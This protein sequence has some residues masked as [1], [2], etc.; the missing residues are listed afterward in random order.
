LGWALFALMT[1]GIVI[2]GLPA[3]SASAAA[4]GQITGT[5][6]Y[7][8]SHPDRT[9]EVYRYTSGTWTEDPSLRTTVASDGS[10]TVQAPAGEPVELR[11]SY[12]Q[13]IYGYFYGDGFDADTATPV[14]AAAGATTTGIDLDVPAPSYLSGRLV[15]RAGQPV[16]GTV[17]PSINNDGSIRPTT[18][19]PIVVDATGTFSVVLPADHEDGLWGSDTAA[20]DGAW[21]GGGSGYEPDW[22]INTVPGETRTAQDIK[23]PVGSAQ[24]VAPAAPA[25]PATTVRFRTVKAPVVHG[26]TR[27][28]A[29]LRS[30][31]GSYSKHPATLRYQWLRNGHAIHGATSSVYHPRAADVRKR[32]S[33]RVTAT[34]SG[35]RVH[36]TSAR[37]AAIRRH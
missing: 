37:T 28:G 21:L 23:L 27:K 6:T 12:G 3:S 11:V 9:L 26:T 1:L 29:I 4:T 25:A 16:A 33:V 17:T 10:Y 18:D 20:T 30:T 14:D 8:E 36:A 24:S 2:A 32:L 31:A 5:V 34:H 19:S 35:S 22:Y 13:P 7:H 15:D